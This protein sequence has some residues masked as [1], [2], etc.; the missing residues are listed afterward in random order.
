[1]PSVSLSKVPLESWVAW[2]DPVKEMTVMSSL[3]QEVIRR[4]ELVKSNIGS[5]Y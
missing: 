2:D 3:S 4:A 1:M 5:S